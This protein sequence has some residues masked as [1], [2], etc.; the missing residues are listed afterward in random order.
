MFLRSSVCAC[1]SSPVSDWLSANSLKCHNCLISREQAFWKVTS[2]ARCSL[3]QIAT[4]SAWC[5][6]IKKRVFRRCVNTLL[7]GSS[8]GTSQRLKKEFSNCGRLTK[9]ELIP[10][11]FSMDRHSVCC[12]RTRW[13]RYVVMVSHSPGFFVFTYTWLKPDLCFCREFTDQFMK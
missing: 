9:K 7:I 12:P 5:S 13:K 11:Y 3:S 6:N 2:C 1:S 4:F 10:I 8:A